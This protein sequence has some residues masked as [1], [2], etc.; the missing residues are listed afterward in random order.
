[1]WM[2]STST[3]GNGSLIAM[4]IGRTIPPAAAPLC[5]KDFWHAVA[6]ACSPVATRRALEADIRSHFGIRHARAVSSG[7]AALTPTLKEV[8]AV[9]PP[10]EGVFP[11]FTPL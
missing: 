3:D 10:R 7:T 11:E 8:N 5:W 2:R 9:W 4:R 1:M 6:G